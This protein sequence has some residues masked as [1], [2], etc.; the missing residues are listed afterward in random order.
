MTKRLRDVVDCDDDTALSCNGLRRGTGKQAKL[1][2][3]I[4]FGSKK[5]SREWDEEERG[6]G[7]GGHFSPPFK[8]PSTTI[9]EA[10]TSHSQHVSPYS[11]VSS[12]SGFNNLQAAG[13]CASSHSLTPPPPPPPP[14]HPYSHPSQ[15]ALSIPP[16]TAVPHFYDSSFTPTNISLLDSSLSR[17]PLGE[18]QPQDDYHRYYQSYGQQQQPHQQHQLVLYTASQQGRI[19][20]NEEEEKEESIYLED[21]SMQ[22]D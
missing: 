14:P 18:Q 4:K 12:L 21:T 8:K 2:H 9:S 17:I 19:T 13:L 22:I 6:G 10:K 15:T 11:L 20:L 1:V 3:S 5:R 7:G 16:A